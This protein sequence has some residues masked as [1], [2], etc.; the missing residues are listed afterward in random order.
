[1]KWA[2]LLRLGFPALSRVGDPAE[3]ILMLDPN[4]KWRG[5]AERASIEMNSEKL[6][7]L[8]EELCREIDQEDE[9]AIALSLSCSNPRVLSNSKHDLKDQL[10]WQA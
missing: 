8:A 10:P 4:G 7:A 6:M 2:I 9:T 3:A 1:V 5:I